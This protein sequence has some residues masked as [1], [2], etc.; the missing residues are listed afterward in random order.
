VLVGARTDVRR[1]YWLMVGRRW[2]IDASLAPI[3][4]RS[5]GAVALALKDNDD[6]RE[7]PRHLSPGTARSL[8]HLRLRRA[9]K[10]PAADVATAFRQAAI[11]AVGRLPIQGEGLAHRAVV[12]VLQANFQ[13][14]DAIEA[15]GTRSSRDAR[16]DDD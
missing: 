12:V 16:L 13:P 8:F 1:L 5:V 15:R 11:L 14:P 2:L 3:L 9:R 6:S 4:G 10:N 7:G